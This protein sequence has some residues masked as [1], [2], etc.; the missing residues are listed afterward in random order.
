MSTTEEEYDRIHS[1]L[2]DEMPL[3]ARLA[4]EQDCATNPSLAEALALE[5]KLVIVIQEHS[6][7]GIRND[8]KLAAQRA[9][10]RKRGRLL[11]F[12]PLTAVAAGL[13]LLLVF[14]FSG[15]T[16]FYSPPPRDLLLEEYK[17]APQAEPLLKV[18]VGQFERM[19]YDS[20]LET[21]RSYPDTAVHASQVHFL[22]GHAYYGLDSSAA[23]VREFSVARELVNPDSKMGRY[24][25][26]YL[27]LAH[28]KGGNRAAAKAG[29]KELKAAQWE[30]MDAVLRDKVSL[31]G[32]ELGE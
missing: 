12:I 9:K 1:Y 31:L 10:R 7:M 6:I 18:A 4:F 16:D 29:L 26:W 32:E 3:E 23:A 24:A 15:P 8:I 14:N 22:R 11:I 20:T 17:G 25:S 5:R 28:L 13:A 19:E 21:L 30:N 27:V 2:L